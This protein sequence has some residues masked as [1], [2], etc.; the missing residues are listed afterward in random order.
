MN[1]AES[2]SLGSL[3]GLTPTDGAHLDGGDDG[4]RG[5]PADGCCFTFG[6]KVEVNEHCNAFV[7]YYPKLN[8]DLPC[9]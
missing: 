2:A 4:T 1:T 6:P 7:Y 9:F 5:N 3:G 8:T